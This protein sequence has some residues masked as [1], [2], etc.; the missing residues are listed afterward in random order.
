MQVGSIVSARS[1]GSTDLCMTRRSDSLSS[2]CSAPDD[3]WSRA[4][5]IR[6]VGCSLHGALSSQY[7]DA[8]ACSH[9]PDHNKHL[10]EPVGAGRQSCACLVRAGRLQGRG[11]CRK[12]LQCPD[13]G[14]QYYRHIH[15]PDRLHTVCRPEVRYSFHDP[16]SHIRR[17]HSFRQQSKKRSRHIRMRNSCLLRNWNKMWRTGSARKSMRRPVRNTHS[18]KS[19]QSVSWQGCMQDHL[20]EPVRTDRHVPGQ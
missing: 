10:P 15:L 13:R 20:A 16:R 4:Q 12:G 19:R 17:R 7:S 11:S 1:V 3:H 8:S 2:A 5:H 6:H 14:R 9:M 18:H